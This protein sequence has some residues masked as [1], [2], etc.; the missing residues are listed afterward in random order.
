[1][2]AV[3]HRLP[4]VV[5]PR[6]DGPYFII[7]AS[8][9]E[10]DAR[11]DL[12][13]HATRV[14]GGGALVADRLDE[15]VRADDREERSAEQHEQMRSHAGGMGMDLALEADEGAEGC[16]DHEPDREVPLVGKLSRV[17]HPAAPPSRLG[18][19]RWSRMVLRW[20][21]QR[22]CAGWTGRRASIYGR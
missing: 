18:R 19:G 17:D 2:A 6:I 11:H 21:I 22:G 10:P 12:G 15:A 16:C 7:R 14:D 9:D 8:A 5:R 13:R 3:A 20:T 1:M 4:A